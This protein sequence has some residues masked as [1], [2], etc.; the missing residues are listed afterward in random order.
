M[1][2]K[3]HP[4]CVGGGFTWKM[5]MLPGP[6]IPSWTDNMISHVGLLSKFTPALSSVLLSFYIKTQ[7][8]ASLQPWVLNSK[9]FQ[10]PEFSLQNVFMGYPISV[11]WWW[12]AFNTSI[13]EAKGGG[14]LWV[15]GQVVYS[16]SS[17][18]AKATQRNRLRI[19]IMLFPGHRLILL[20]TLARK[21]SLSS[22]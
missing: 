5:H 7:Y 16:A 20:L 2:W 13:W 17:K 12:H 10:P 6:H 1:H 3:F 21:A 14:S 22:G 18:T 11:G 9:A 15:Q 8:K 19:K 4:K